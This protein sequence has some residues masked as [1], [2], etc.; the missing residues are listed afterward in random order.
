MRQTAQLGLCVAGQGLLRER[1]KANSYF[2]K[3]RNML[4]S[5]PLHTG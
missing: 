4:H 1:N 2:T 3:Y 5:K